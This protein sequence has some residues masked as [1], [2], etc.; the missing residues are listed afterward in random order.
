MN[1]CE[2]TYIRENRPIRTMEPDAVPLARCND[3]LVEIFE[4][5]V[6]RS[7][8]RI[9]LARYSDDYVKS[10]KSL[11]WRHPI[12]VNPRGLISELSAVPTLNEA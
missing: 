4:V 11:V 5:R 12:P 10:D 6:N 7:Y 1:I 9:T 2:R 3:S 8:L